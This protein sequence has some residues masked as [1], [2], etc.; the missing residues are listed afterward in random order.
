MLNTNITHLS[1]S[2][3]YEVYCYL[4]SKESSLEKKLGA[5]QYKLNIFSIEPHKA[6]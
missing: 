2:N 3:L 5:A 6:N 1:T 4:V